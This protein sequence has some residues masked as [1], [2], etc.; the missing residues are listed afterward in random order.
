MSAPRWAGS[1]TV[2][3]AKVIWLLGVVAWYLVRHPFERRSRR[4]MIV[5]RL[6]RARELVLMAVAFLG[7]IAV[8]F[9]Y[10]L[11]GWPQFADYPFPSVQGFAGAM[12]LAG[13]LW[14]LRRSH[15]DLG[16]NWSVMLEIRDDHRLTTGGIYRRLRHPMYAAFWLWALAQALLLPNWIA[17]PAGLVGFG[18]LF[19][20]RVGREERLML[21]TFGE[22][23][24]AY[25]ARTHRII[26]GIY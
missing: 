1:M 5:R 3:V 16:S 26:P 20:G 8:P 19:F 12:A 14:L 24:R 18:A 13:A 11:G 7:L 23:Y 15:H 22:D 4:L 2:V 6:D 9:A 21:E 10:V 17:G 25:M